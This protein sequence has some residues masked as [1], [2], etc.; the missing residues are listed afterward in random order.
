[1]NKDLCIIMPAENMDGNSST[2]T[3]SKSI[4]PSGTY[5]TNSSP[6]LH[7]AILLAENIFNPLMD[8]N[9]QESISIQLTIRSPKDENVGVNLESIGSSCRLKLKTMYC[10]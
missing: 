3:S 10:N 6:V 1:M 7:K 8:D 9:L 5:P 2:P 4:A